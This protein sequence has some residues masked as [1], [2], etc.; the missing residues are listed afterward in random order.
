MKIKFT[1]VKLTVAK[2]FGRVAALRT[3]RF[4]DVIR[5]TATTSAQRV[6][7]VMPLSEA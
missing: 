6:G 2:A 7:L 1:Q 3:S 5:G 4:L